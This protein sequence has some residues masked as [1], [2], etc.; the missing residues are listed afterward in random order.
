MADERLTLADAVAAHQAELL[1]MP[2]VVG[3]AGGLSHAHPGE[4]VILVYVTA[5]TELPPTL[6]GF[7][8]EV[9]PTAGFEPL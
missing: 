2:G 1:A 9:V 7:I 8:V 6:S 3:V 4:T 5:P